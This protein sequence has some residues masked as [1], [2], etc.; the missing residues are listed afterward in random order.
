MITRIERL[1]GGNN[2]IELKVTSSSYE[3]LHMSA[4][5]GPARRDGGDISFSLNRRQA[6]QVADTLRAMAFSVD[7]RFD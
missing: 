7:H 3:S 5:I 1:G 2:Y 4:T 6:Y